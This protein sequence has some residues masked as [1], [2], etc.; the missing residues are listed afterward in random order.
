[1]ITSLFVIYGREGQMQGYIHHS[2]NNAGELCCRHRKQ[3]T[4][5]ERALSGEF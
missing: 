5:L 3:V 4:L 2:Y 1:M